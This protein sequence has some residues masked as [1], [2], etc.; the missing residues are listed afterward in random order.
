[1]N[2]EIEEALNVMARFIGRAVH[3]PGDLDALEALTKVKSH[4][5]VLEFAAQHRWQ[6]MEAAEETLH[7][8]AEGDY[9]KMITGDFD[10]Y[11]DAAAFARS[12][13]ARRQA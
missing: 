3:V 7:L 6:R 2:D 8:I 11:G 10:P 1:M 4:I 13:L 9:P 12:T 5:K